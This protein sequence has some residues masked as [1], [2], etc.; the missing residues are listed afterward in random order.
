MAFIE[1]DD[2]DVVNNFTIAAASTKEVF[3]QWLMELKANNPTAKITTLGEGRYQLVLPVI[4]CTGSDVYTRFNIPYMHQLLRVGTKHTD[5][6]DVDSTDSLAYS[7]SKRYYPNLWMLL[8]NIDSSIASDILDEYIDYYM[9]LG[10][11]L[12]T[13]NSTNTDRLYINIVIKITGA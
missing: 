3:K 8:L 13:S 1:I 11:Y 9:E 4:T 6:N 2:R 10:E 7:L 12:I 5:S